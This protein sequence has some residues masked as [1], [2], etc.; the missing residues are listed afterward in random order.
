MNKPFLPRLAI[1][2]LVCAGAASGHPATER[3]IPIGYWAE[4]SDRQTYIGTI[5]GHDETAHALNVE[6]APGY[7][8]YRKV[9]VTEGTRVYLDRSKL[10]RTNL[11]GTY[12]DC[13][14][15]RT[16]EVRFADGSDEAKWVKVL[17]TEP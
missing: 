1:L 17:I 3:Y 12:A 13:R 16:V 10:K 4:V 14:E 11:E 6:G 2:G 9:V 15:G 8:G 7:E 5:K